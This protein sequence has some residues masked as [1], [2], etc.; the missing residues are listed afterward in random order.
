MALLVSPDANDLLTAVRSLL[1]Q[2]SEVNSFWTDDELLA[3][4]NAGIKRYFTLITQFGQGQ[5]TTTANLNIVGNQETVPLPADFFMAK[6]LSKMASDGQTFIPLDYVNNLTEVWITNASGGD[7]FC[8]SWY[9]RGSN[10]VLR[11]VSNSSETGTLL[12]EYVQFPSILLT[13]GDTLNADVSPVFRELIEMFA[14]Y[15]A[16]LK[17]S[18]VTGVNT[19]S[20]AEEHVG[21]LATELKDI[22]AKR[23][24]GPTYTVQFAPEEF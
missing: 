1:N 18:L 14:V 16:K 15:K 5:F 3:Y 9:I 21:A 24:L 8:P 6:S 2:P 22:M 20:G 4:M 23:S 13:G 11:P 17:E 19:Y 10:I 12:L 7:G